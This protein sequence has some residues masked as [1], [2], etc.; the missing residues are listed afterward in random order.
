MSSLIL[1]IIFYCIAVIGILT[2]WLGWRNRSGMARWC[3]L[4]RTDMSETESR[5]CQ[6]CGF[7]SIEERSFHVPQ[8]R[9]GVILAGLA[10]TAAAS[11]GAT[12]TGLGPAVNQLFVPLWQ[13]ESSVELPGGWVAEIRRSRDLDRSGFRSRVRLIR[14]GIP[15]F[16]WYGW[17]ASFGAFKSGNSKERWGLGEDVDGDGTRD[18]I[19]ETFDG[20]GQSGLRAIVL[21]LENTE[22]LPRIEP[23]AILGGGRFGDVDDD[24]QAEFLV[25]DETF[26]FRLGEGA[27]RTQPILVFSPDDSGIWRF[28]PEA[29]RNRAMP[30]D[31]RQDLENEHM[32]MERRGRNS[33]AAYQSMALELIYRGRMAEAKDLLR[34]GFDADEAKVRAFLEMLTESPWHLEVESLNRTD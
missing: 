14:D 13:L 25:E 11:L 33:A 1:T 18:L 31:W 9:W 17:Y 19:I 10:I 34:E 23:M 8:R 7:S 5:T 29:T 27:T 21:S 20:T 6:N 4:C 32:I 24:G 12:R 2:T 16:E 22:G 3:P 30:Q 28:D 15:R 26:Q